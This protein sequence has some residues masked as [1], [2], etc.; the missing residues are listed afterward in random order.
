MLTSRMS[1]YH[2]HISRIPVN[3]LTPTPISLTFI[4]SNASLRAK[5]THLIIFSRSS[6]STDFNDN[7]FTKEGKQGTLGI[8]Q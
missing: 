7:P 5:D 8:N 3:R 6:G 2:F 1:H 4:F